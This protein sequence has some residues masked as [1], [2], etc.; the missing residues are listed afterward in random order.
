MK[1]AEFI[2][3]KFQ[4]WANRKNIRLQGSEGERGQPNYT[5]NLGENLFGRLH[6]QARSL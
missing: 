2:Q 3:R 5:L 1:S 6:S 4:A